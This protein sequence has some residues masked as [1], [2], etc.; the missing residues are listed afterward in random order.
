MQAQGDDVV[1]PAGNEDDRV[2][3]VKRIAGLLDVHASTIY[4]AIGDGRLYAVRVGGRR[5]GLRVPHRAY[6]DFLKDSGT[7]QPSDGE[8][9]A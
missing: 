7:T 4:R 5:G 3:R 2:Y 8:Q 6:L 9:V 1:V